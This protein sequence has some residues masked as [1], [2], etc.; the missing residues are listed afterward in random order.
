MN[1]I[2]LAVIAESGVLE[3][4]A[5]LLC[6]S[7][8]RFAGR[9]ADIAI[10]AISP[11]SD[12]RPCIA[13]LARFAELG[14]QYLALDVHSIAPEYGVTFR[15]YAAAEFERRSKA[16][17]ILFVDSDLLFAAEPDLDLHG[18]DVLA[19][20][21][22]VKGMCTTGAGDPNDLYWR[23]L[24]QICEVDYDAVPE[25]R[26]TVEK[27]M[28]KASYNGG[29]VMVRRQDGVFARTLDYFKRSV[30]A[31]LAP[32]R[33]SGMRVRAAHGLVTERG[34]E[35]WGSSQACLSLAIW[36]SGLTV[37]SPDLSHNFPLNNFEP[38]TADEQA[39]P[40]KVIHYHHLLDEDP[41]HNPLFDGRANVSAEFV[42]WLRRAS[43]EDTAQPELPAQSAGHDAQAVRDKT[44][45]VVLGMHRSGTSTITRGLKAIGV[46]L[47]DMLMPGVA[48]DNDKGFFE[49]LDI[50][51][52]NLRLMAH[53]GVDWDDLV[54]P[55]DLAPDGPLMAEFFAPAVALLSQKLQRHAMFGFKDP[56]VSRLLPFWQ[57]VFAELGVPVRYVIAYRNPA[58]VAFS[59][60][61]RNGIDPGKG[62]Y[63]W[64]VHQMESLLGCEGQPY[65]VVSY[66]RML[67]HPLEQLERLW[68][69]LALPEPEAS[70]LNA[71]AEFLSPALRH[72]PH[73]EAALTVADVPPEVLALNL[74]LA[75]LANDEWP[76]GDSRLRPALDALSQRLRELAPA[77]HLVTRLDAKTRDLRQALAEAQAQAQYF[78][79]QHAQVQAQLQEQVQEQSQARELAQAQE[80]AQAQMQAHEQARAMAQMQA[81]RDA[82]RTLLESMTQSKSRKLLR[83]LRQLLIPGK[84]K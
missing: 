79:Q 32:F 71:Y 56:R 67:E 40:L 84:R 28:V 1:T 26:T 19:R 63:L 14:V 25:V 59:L 27:I 22:D 8:R 33:G 69:W 51:R 4:Q 65:I 24:C 47:G 42:G 30:T 21:V 48:D 70:A 45:V 54:V 52:F 49:D 17:Q 73:S 64:L 77:L 55:L 2:D 9:H 16:D 6:E 44:I 39:T 50:S 75:R 23:K 61:R 76:A 46:G 34:S 81:E 38:L 62:H 20:A 10:T 72:A 13:T 18:A 15:M 7:V 3:K 36:G 5:V 43:T 78:A 60:G 11:R 12:R 68:T 58:S 35:F 83:A 80:Q 37:H 82:A 53:I 29:F 74:L 57:R 31:G 41:A 66:D